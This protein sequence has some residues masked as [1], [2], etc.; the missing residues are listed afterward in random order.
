MH[1]AQAN[2]RL[3]QS[4]AGRDAKDGIKTAHGG[5]NQ[6][7]CTCESDVNLEPHGSWRTSRQSG[8]CRGAT[9]LSRG[10]PYTVYIQIAASTALRRNLRL[11]P[12]EVSLAWV[13]LYDSHPKRQTVHCH[14]STPEAMAP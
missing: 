8:E 9:Q 2:A 6:Q 1:P 11:A 7:A 13:A 10:A 5:S 14:L 3:L 12:V 4:R